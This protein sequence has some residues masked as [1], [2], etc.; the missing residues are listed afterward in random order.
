MYYKGTKTKCI[1]YNNKVT[2][3]EKY[4][5]STLAWSNV[6]KNNNGQGFAILK[7]ENYTSDMT[8]INQ[9]P[10]DWNNEI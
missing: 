3:G 6:V 2:Q 10:D 4:Q 9:I 1:S 8:L 5:S 7:H